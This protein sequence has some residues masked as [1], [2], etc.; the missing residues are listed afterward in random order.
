M[1]KNFLRITVLIAAAGFSISARA[2][3]PTPTTEDVAYELPAMV[4]PKTVPLFDNAFAGMAGVKVSAFCYTLNLVVFEVDRTV[5]K[6]NASIEEKIHSI[7]LTNDSMMH[8]QPKVNFNKDSWLVM[9]SE[10]DLIKR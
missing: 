1:T 4:S 9:C 10:Q 8:L 7:F 6:D 2:Q 3:Q 5:Q